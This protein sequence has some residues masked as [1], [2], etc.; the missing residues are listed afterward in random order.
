MALRVHPQFFFVVQNQ[1][2]LV[3]IQQQQQKE[4]YWMFYYDKNLKSVNISDYG[5]GIWKLTL[6]SLDITIILGNNLFDWVE[7]FLKFD[8]LR[9]QKN[10]FHSGGIVDSPKSYLKCFIL[11]SFGNTKLV[12]TNQTPILIS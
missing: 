10:F 1:F 8:S 4:N 2:Q 11:Y 9:K 7:L 5:L 3:S 12:L 6:G